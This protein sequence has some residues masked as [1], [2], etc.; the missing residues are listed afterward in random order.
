M[1][2]PFIPTLLV[3]CFLAGCGSAP[4]AA[5]APKA[6]D[7]APVAGGAEKNPD[8]PVAA[9]ALKIPAPAGATGSVPVPALADAPPRV[10]QGLMLTIESLKP[11]AGE[12][13]ARKDTRS[14]RLIALY[15]SEGSAPTP[16]LP[17]GP[18][19]ATW[20]G[21]MT[22]G[23]RDEYIFSADGRGKLTFLV[24]EQPV[25]ESSGEDLAKTPGKKV[26]LNKGKNKITALYESPEKGD[27]FIRLFWESA[28]GEF[29]RE[30]LPIV[31][32]SHD[33]DQKPLRESR[34]L[35]EGRELF[36]T[37]RC[38]QC[39]DASELMPKALPAG[40]EE[41]AGMPELEID[42]PN[43]SDAGARLN[44]DW[45]AKWITHPRA[46]RPESSMPQ[47][48]HGATLAKDAADI[49]GF[50]A[51]LGKKDDGPAEAPPPAEI[52]AG[53]VLVAKLGCIGC[54]TLPQ[55][56]KIEA[57]RIPLR[58]VRAKWNPGALK[59][60]LKQPD[61]HYAWIRMPNFRFSDDEI[62]KLSAFLLHSK[63]DAKDWPI[64]KLAAAPDVEKGK[65][66]VQST[67][68]LSCHNMGEGLANTVKAPAVKS[69]P[70]A[71][72][73]RGCMAPKNDG[74][75]PD[76]SFTPAQHNALLA[77]TGE[78][79]IS[80]IAKGGLKG[81]SLLAET[82]P[83]FTER[84]IKQLRCAACHRRDS[85]DDLWSGFESEVEELKAAEVPPE[86]KEGEAPE[87][88]LVDQI[89]PQL[90]WTGEKLKPEWTADFISGKN[91][92][93]MRT[94]LFAR[95]PNFPRRASLLAKGLV[96]EHGYRPV[97][98]T[99]P[100]PDEKLAEIGRK[101]TGQNGGLACTKCHS[102]GATEAV[103]VFEAPGINLMHTKSRL[104]KTY[105][106][107]WIRDPLRVEAG[108]KMPTFATQGKTQLNDV[109][110][111]DATQQFESIWQY[112]LY[113]DKIVAPEE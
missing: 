106:H 13:E 40:T 36:A 94:W 71:G 55:N 98:A 31:Q 11:A 4:P 30:P 1:R 75:S 42:A 95:M 88:L 19:K 49:A 37:M 87:P 9:T 82:L 45:M 47:V 105:F 16:F 59:S 109:Y 91:T 3:L 92:K 57:E 104:L 61:K 5:T 8:V 28:S 76:F 78:I 62:N 21:E 73:T 102:V 33:V 32:L 56:E 22:V 63:I 96:I 41:L 108:S 34:R 25:L 72:W 77:F 35:R 80:P 66:L 81:G 23:M 7:A 90:T 101:L 46:L 100:P 26:K 51:T 64:T 86:P 85:E 67:G 14:S 53:G 29:V 65:K 58:F 10:A 111:G 20:Q 60:F 68:C 52:A 39:H 44:V 6:P 113:G 83:E 110:D 89:R 43:L 12:K 50:L 38:T 27:S 70:D 79:P 2:A 84:Q 103:G 24:N 69:I 112:L 107:R 93:K 18:V 15:V 48:L 74:K 97:S 17:P 99:E 54:H